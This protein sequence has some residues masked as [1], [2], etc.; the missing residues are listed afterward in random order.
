MK[1]TQPLSIEARLRAQ[2]ALD[3]E[4]DAGN[5]LAFEA[6][7]AREEAL[8]SYY[9]RLAATRD[10]IKA[11]AP[12]EAAPD[13]LRARLHALAEAPPASEPKSKPWAWTTQRGTWAPMALAA[14]LAFAMFVG[15]VTTRMTLVAANEDSRL[16]A[17]VS[18]YVR[19][20]VSG[21]PFDVASSDRHTVKPW[22]ASRVTLG[23]VV[24]DLAEAGYPLAGGRIDVVD[25]IPVPTLVYRR[26]EHF[27]TVSEL[28]SSPRDASGSVS[29]DGYHLERWADSERAY[30]AISDLDAADLVDFARV[31]RDA[32]RAPSTHGKP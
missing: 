10:A 7:L 13:D 8:R 11:A 9:Q 12:R 29:I 19:G 4:L 6:D 23:A 14:S 32:A 30:V 15:S 31:F 16:Q 2:A 17:L 18:G 25:R 28:A 3:G 21:Q 22:L 1:E 24:I 5:A 27:I 20:Q 26:R